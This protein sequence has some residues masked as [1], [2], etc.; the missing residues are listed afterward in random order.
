[1]R[2][3]VWDEAEKFTRCGRLRWVV[4]GYSGLGMETTSGPTREPVALLKAL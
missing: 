3:S 1:M 4:G 2:Q